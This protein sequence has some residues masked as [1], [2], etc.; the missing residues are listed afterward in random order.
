MQYYARINDLTRNTKILTYC[1]IS[2]YVESKTDIHLLDYIPIDMLI[3]MYCARGMNC[4]TDN[5]KAGLRELGIENLMV[6]YKIYAMTKMRND[7]MS[8]DA[9][10]KSNSSTCS[11]TSTLTKSSGTTDDLITEMMA[12]DQTRFDFECIQ[13]LGNSY[14]RLSFDAEPFD[15]E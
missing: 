1:N 15:L 8:F 11:K 10:Y 2:F 4:N 13:Y 14:E 3:N 5:F 12:V 7:S 9:F 6:I